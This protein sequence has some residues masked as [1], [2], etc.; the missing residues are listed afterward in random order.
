MWSTD[1]SGVITNQTRWKTGDQML[2]LGYEDTFARDFNRDGVIGA[3]PVFDDDGDGLVDG[4]SSYKLFKDGQAITLTNSRGRAFS[5][6]SSRWWDAVQAVKTD[7]GFQVLLEGNRGRRSGRYLVW[8][9][10]AAGVVTHN[11]G[12]KTGQQMF[13]LGYEAIFNRDFDGDNLIGGR[14]NGTENADLI[15]GTG[16][17]DE[18]YGLGG[19][20]TIYGGNGNDSIMGGEGS[21]SINGGLGNDR[22][23][24]YLGDDSIH[25]GDGDDSIFGGYG[26]DT[27]SGDDGNDSIQTN[28]GLN[29]L[30]GGGGNDTIIGGEDGDTIAGGEGD[31]DI[32]GEQGA[33]MINGDIGSDTIF[34]GYGD[35][36]ING[37]DGN[38]N[39]Y[40]GQG[41]DTINGGAGAD[42]LTCGSGVDLFIQNDGDSVRY[43]AQNAFSGNALVTGGTFTFGNSVDRITDFTGGVGGDLINVVTAGV[44]TILSAGDSINELIPGNNYLIRGDF[45][46]N[47]SLFTQSNVGN[48]A[49]I[50]IDAKNASLDDLSNDDYL[51]VEGAG[52]TLVAANFI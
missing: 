23:L 28:F 52:A 41:N 4:S 22:I 34:G 27:I 33:D 19:N 11:S 50:L 48:D 15:E 6:R 31:D 46:D 8:T 5:D 37:D 14:I 21:D 42:I 49:L 1:A 26:N 30:S 9:T 43:T 16:L 7:A 45:I 29:V 39:I 47:T 38:D 40:A 32:R 36:T 17:S 44:I 35:D 13:D 24:G 12:W 10:N 18:I 51:I 25:G 2:E 20:D 3:P